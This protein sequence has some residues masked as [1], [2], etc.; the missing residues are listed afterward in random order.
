MRIALI[1]FLLLSASIAHAQEGVETIDHVVVRWSSRATGGVKKPQFIT[2]RELAFEA[3][4]EALTEGRRRP[5]AYSNKHVHSAIQHNITETMLASLP[6]DPRPTP[7]QVGTYAEAARAILAQRIGNGDA[8]IG[9]KKIDEARRAEGITN[10]EL[11]AIL[12]RRARA[13]WYLD[14]MVAP[15]L[16]PSELD[17]REVH[18]RGE[19]PFTSQKFDV[20]EKQLRQWYVSTRIASALERY[21]RNART[22]INVFV[23]ERLLPRAPRGRQ[24]AR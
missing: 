7:K 21:F 2:A 11:D 19:T 20:V 12:R 15:M 1:V 23:I 5:R 22:R 16:R 24:Q 4:V 6:V 10:K 14:K 3:R 13:S 9:A 8:T 18:K 17:L